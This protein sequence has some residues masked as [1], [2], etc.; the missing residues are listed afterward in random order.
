MQHDDVCSHGAAVLAQTARYDQS[1]YLP[2]RNK[3]SV[4]AQIK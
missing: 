4:T 2:E 1:Q 3:K